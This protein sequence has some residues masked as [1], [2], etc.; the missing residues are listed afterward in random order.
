MPKDLQLFILGEFRGLPQG[1]V[2]SER[3]GK[4]E[5]DGR[6][7]HRLRLADMQKSNRGYE[8]KFIYCL[9]IRKRYFGRNTDPCSRGSK[10]PLKKLGK[11]FS[12]VI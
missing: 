3:F 7:L 11:I 5:R 2:E 4:L 8:R 10:E 9:G 1:V 12:L 6:I